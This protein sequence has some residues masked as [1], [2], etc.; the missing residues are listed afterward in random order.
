LNT[1][2][3]FTNPAFSC[4]EDKQKKA[5]A[6]LF[7]KLQGKTPE[8]A[9]AIIMHFMQTM[10]KDKGHKI[11]PAERQAM[12]AVVTADMSDKEKKNVETIMKLLL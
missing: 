9:A 11:T 5:F 2:E 6:E 1:E 10:P 3:F 4:L 8:Q 7:N 12:L